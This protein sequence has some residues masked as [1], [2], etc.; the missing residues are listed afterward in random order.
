MSGE[1]FGEYEKVTSTLMHMI[2]G[3]SDVKTNTAKR[4]GK[5]YAMGWRG[6]ML[7]I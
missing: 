7:S 2:K 1:E 5:M 6:G 3:A 4:S